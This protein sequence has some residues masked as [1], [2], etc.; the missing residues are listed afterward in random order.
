MLQFIRIIAFIQSYA[1]SNGTGDVMGKVI[2]VTSG[3]GGT[4]KSTFCVC[5][6]QSLAGRGKRVLLID[7]DEG[8]RCLDIL[9]G[10]ESGLVFDLSDVIAGRPVEDAV[11][12]SSENSGIYLIPA[13]AEPGSLSVR[14][15]ED[16]TGRL[17]PEY[18]YLIFDFPAGI[19]FSLCAA[20]PR[21]TQMIA[22][23]CPDAVSV[24][25]AAE[26]CR[27]LPEFDRAPVL[28]LNRFV[29]GDMRNGSVR[30]IDDIIDSSGFRMLGIIPESRELALL[31]SHNALK[32]GGKPYRAFDRIAG[33]LCGEHIKLP[34]P[35]KI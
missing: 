31:A 29:A 19:D 18:D 12:S 32:R 16:V 24:R 5:L 3:K 28:V 33:R 7:L 13:P 23:C 10:V 30:C 4:G 20:L 26:V 11:Y 15:L 27:R 8:L 14:A 6:A 9:L 17:I 34:P 21:Q 22:V 1:F 2:A 35:K 25:D